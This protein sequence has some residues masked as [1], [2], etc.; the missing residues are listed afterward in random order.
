MVDV[1]DIATRC[2][3]PLQLAGL[4]VI[5]MFFIIIAVI[6]YLTIRFIGKVI[7]H[8]RKADVTVDKDDV[9]ISAHLS[10]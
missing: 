3:T 4:F 8:F 9:H 6:A 2:N 10:Q 1:F 5:A 7:L